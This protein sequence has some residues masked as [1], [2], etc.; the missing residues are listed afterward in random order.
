[1]SILFDLHYAT[2]PD[3]E[4]TDL[5]RRRPTITIIDKTKTSAALISWEAN[6]YCFAVADALIMYL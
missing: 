5:P 4:K 3:I 1:M 6:G 2:G